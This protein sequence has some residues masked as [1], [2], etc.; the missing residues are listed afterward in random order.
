[1]V[2]QDQIDSV[3]RLSYVPLLHHRGIYEQVRHAATQSDSA[4]CRHPRKDSCSAEIS[5][6][7]WGE[8]T[9]DA[10]DLSVPTMTDSA[11]DTVATHATSPLL[12]SSLV[13]TGTNTIKKRSQKG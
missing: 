1:M 12:F 13:S 11:A 10:T 4:H 2:Q 6:S 8:V 9:V 5:N 3:P 7:S